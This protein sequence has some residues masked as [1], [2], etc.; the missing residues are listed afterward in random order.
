MALAEGLSEK[1]QVLVDLPDYLR[2]NSCLTVIHCTGCR[3][4]L[5]MRNSNIP[6]RKYR[7]CIQ[8]DCLTGMDQ[9]TADM[10]IE[11]DDVISRRLPRGCLISRISVG[12]FSTEGP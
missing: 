3:L 4:N 12:R 7:T 1:Q 11:Y 2:L 6:V 5:N 10:C 8:E 9:F